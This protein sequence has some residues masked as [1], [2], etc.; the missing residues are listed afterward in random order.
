MKSYLK[1]L[2]ITACLAGLLTSCD[3][4]DNPQPVIDP[5]GSVSVKAFVLCQG[6]SYAK[7]PGEL[8]VLDLKQLSM[9]RSV[10]KKTNNR[11]L[12]DTPQCGVV[13]GSKVYI[14]MSES[15]TID[16]I[17]QYTYKSLSQ[18]RLSKDPEGSTPRSMVAYGGKVYISL[19]EGYVARL[20]TLT[21]KIDA[22]VKV[23]KNPENM[24]L[25][26]GKLYVPN[27]EGM[28][29]LAGTPYGKTAS[30]VTLEPFAEERT[31]EV[32][33]NPDAFYSDGD[34]LYLLCK[35]NYGSVPSKLYK[36]G[37]DLGYTSIAPATKVAYGFKKI[38]IANQPFDATASS[39]I[40][41]S[42]SIYDCQTG[43]MSSV[44]LP[45]AKSP[46]GLA[47]SPIDGS[48]FVTAYKVPEGM[49]PEYKED[50]T[51]HIYSQSGEA[52]SHFATGVGAEAI[53][54]NVKL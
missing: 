45:E 52:V 21:M 22:H 26:D 35:G 19:Y 41:A 37:K 17:D 36:I 2:A 27:S 43:K 50:C 40:P 9:N 31:F 33:E 11:E 51:L 4:D 7:I 44:Q 30:V 10:F 13:Y 46:A 29:Y 25:H 49:F 8:D 15:Q 1:H 47:V 14:G 18:L 24:C 53:F 32:P 42:Y 38:L 48:L 12:G 23:G 5:V 34:N 6:Q 39:F 20:D 3:K 16:V 54:F 28:N